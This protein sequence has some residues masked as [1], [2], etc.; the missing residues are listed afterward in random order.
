MLF[1]RHRDLEGKHAILSAS[2]WR[3]INDDET[4]LTKRICSQ[5]LPTVGTILHEMACRHIRYRVLIEDND[6]KNVIL[7]LLSNGIPK[8]VIESI[9]MDAM[10]DNFRAYVNDCVMLKMEPEVVLCYSDNCFGTTDAIKF[11]EEERLLRIN[12]YKSGT[13]P[14]HMEQLLIYAALFCLEY[15]IDPYT[16]DT[17]LRIY[18]NND[19]LYGNPTSDEIR[20]TMDTI[21]VH[22]NLTNHIKRG[23]YTS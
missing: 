9:D 19:I 15:R 14:A 22:D 16:I 21:I 7:E 23:G 5:Y 4:S 12:D 3:W 1:N 2:S 17:K 8:V 10:F 11:S 20:D 13:T 6:K 18:Q